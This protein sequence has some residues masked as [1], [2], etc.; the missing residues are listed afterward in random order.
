LSKLEAAFPVRIRCVVG[1]GVHSAEVRVRQLENSTG[2]NRFS[3]APPL[4]LFEF[5]DGSIKTSVYRTLQVIP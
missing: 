3:E 1:A 5:G 2:E 4:E